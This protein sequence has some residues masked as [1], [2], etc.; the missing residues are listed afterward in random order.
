LHDASHPLASAA[1]CCAI[2]VHPVLSPVP[3]CLPR[4]CGCHP[5]LA[6]A[7]EG[8]ATSTIVLGEAHPRESIRQAAAAQQSRAAHVHGEILFFFLLNDLR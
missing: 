1:C 6:T 3:A 8:E 5:V 2:D 4:L 7:R